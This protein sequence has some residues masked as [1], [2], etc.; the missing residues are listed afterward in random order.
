MGPNHPSHSIPPMTA[1]AEAGI[2]ISLIFRWIRQA[3]FHFG[4][5][6]AE[7][8]ERRIDF[9]EK[10]GGMPKQDAAPDTR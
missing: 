8:Q 3:K 1:M 5:R 2:R 7:N 6:G 9:A 10:S 4:K